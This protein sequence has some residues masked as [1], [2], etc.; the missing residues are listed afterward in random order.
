MEEEFDNTLDKLQE[1]FDLLSNYKYELHYR[2]DCEY[3]Y[4]EEGSV[5]ITILNPYSENKMY[6]DLEEEFTLSYGVYHEHFYPD[7]DGYNEMVKT[8]NGILD[9]ELCSAT[10]YSGQPLKWL[11]ST[12]ITKAESLQL[13]IKDVFSFILK[14]KE[15]KIRLHTDGGEVHYDFWNPMDDRVVII[16]KKA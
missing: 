15:F 5:C 10:M 16:K 13:P 7:C 4:L 1:L 8:I 6:I 11:G 3:E 12:T 14:I 2:D 9:N